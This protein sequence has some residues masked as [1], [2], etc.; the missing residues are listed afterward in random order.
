MTER[1]PIDGCQA[2]PRLSTG[3]PGLDRI[4][5]GGLIPG[6][7]YAVQGGPGTGKTLLGLHFLAC[8]APAGR[9]LLVTLGEDV[10]RLRTNATQLGI[11]LDEVDMLDLGLFKE[12]RALAFRLVS[13][14][15]TDFHRIMHELI[16]TVNRL[17]PVRIFVDFARTLRLLSPDPYQYRLAMLSILRLFRDAGATSLVACEQVP[18]EP[19]DLGFMVDGVFE[20][21]SRPVLMTTDRTI[22]VI[23]TRGSDFKGGQHSLK[24][25]CEGLA[26]IPHLF[27]SQVRIR[28]GSLA[29]QN[30]GVPGLDSI[31]GGGIEAGSITLLTGSAGTGKTLMGLQMMLAGCRR[32]Q[33]CLVYTFDQE[34]RVMIRQL[35]NL[36]QD[37]ADLMARGLFT[38][39]RI[40]PHLLSADEF[41]DLMRRELERSEIGMVM[42]DSTAGYQ[43]AVRD[44]QIVARLHALCKF[45]QG[46]GVTVILTTEIRSLGTIPSVTDQ[47][48]SYLVDNVILLRHWDAPRAD[49]GVELRK[50]LLVLKK[51]LSAFDHAVHE[52]VI[53]PGGASIKGPAKGIGAFFGDGRPGAS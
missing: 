18:G 27:T 42:L 22:R 30:T 23:K 15:E 21:S 24:L 12:A 48:F 43:L 14:A 36:G 17:A 11:L 41:E 8:K 46:E 4:L 1:A 38:L 10:E 2:G 33:K 47:R 37:P 51:R 6:N 50:L 26:V 5:C 31:L 44:D 25:G 32:G 34:P 7:A 28:E 45:L 35:E 53:G 16:Q 3:V 49:G 29:R 39:T 19:D 52:V 20:V 40:E 13:P 9:R